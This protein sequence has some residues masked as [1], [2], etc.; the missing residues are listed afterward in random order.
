MGYSHFYRIEV[1][2][3]CITQIT[4]PLDTSQAQC[5]SHSRQWCDLSVG[6]QT[7]FTDP[8]AISNHSHFS[9]LRGCVLLS[10]TNVLIVFW[11]VCVCVWCCQRW[12][13]YFVLCYLL[14]SFT[15]VGRMIVTG[16]ETRK[17]ISESAILFNTT[18]TSCCSL[19]VYY[20]SP[21]PS[22]MIWYL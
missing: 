18:H 21:L 17:R 19:K 2:P 13:Q 6:R 16:V 15:A 20:F 4:F 14:H 22:E 5:G 3:E 8:A 7:L 9:H 10:L 11:G 1:S 12:C